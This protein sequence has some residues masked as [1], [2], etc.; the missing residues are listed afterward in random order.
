MSDDQYNYQHYESATLNLGTSQQ[1]TQTFQ[2]STPVSFPVKKIKFK[3]AYGIVADALVNYIASTTIED[4]EIVGSLGK[5]VFTDGFGA[6]YFADSLSEQ[7]AISHIYP[8]PKR[9]NG[10]ISITFQQI[11]AGA[12][13]TSARVFVLIE[14]LG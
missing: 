6:L 9:I 13:I 3:F 5:Y 14:F 11:L 1:T 4:T 8:L 10:N 2:M 7:T 12:I